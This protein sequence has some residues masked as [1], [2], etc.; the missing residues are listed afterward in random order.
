MRI[1]PDPASQPVPCPNETLVYNCTVNG[2]I[3]LIWTSNATENVVFTGQTMIED[4]RSASNS[5]FVA[6]LNSREPVENEL[7]LMIS[8]LVISPPL[9]EFNGLTL[10]CIGRGAVIGMD[11]MKMAIVTVSGE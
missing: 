5:Q 2:Y 10:S 4:P 9:N 11:G 3:G 8:T 7:L 1:E 6:T